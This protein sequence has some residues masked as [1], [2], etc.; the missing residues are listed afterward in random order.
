MTDDHL[1][2]CLMWDVKVCMCIC[3]ELRACEARVTALATPE[4]V[5]QANYWYEQGQRDVFAYH[6]E[7]TVTDICKPDCLPCQRLTE[8]ITEREKG[9]EEGQRDERE[10]KVGYYSQRC[11][12][13]DHIRSQHALTAGGCIGHALFGRP[14]AYCPCSEFEG[15]SDD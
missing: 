14:G 8:L 3:L 6:P 1:P 10:R 7:W 5:M 2:E 9:Y 4:T 12:N 11:L 13:C 15:D